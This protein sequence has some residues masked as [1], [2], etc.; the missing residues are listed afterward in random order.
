VFDSCWS[1]KYPFRRHCFWI[2]LIAY[3]ACCP[4]YTA[5]PLPQDRSWRAAKNWSPSSAKF[6]LSIRPFAAWSVTEHFIVPTFATGEERSL[7]FFK[8]IR[9]LVACKCFNAHAASSTYSN[10]AEPPKKLYPYMGT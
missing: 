8:A 2:C 7:P 3:P 6:S 4:M 5:S 10:L 1:R 9:C